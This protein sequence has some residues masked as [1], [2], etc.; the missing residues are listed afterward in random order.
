MHVRVRFRARMKVLTFCQQQNYISPYVCRCSQT[1]GRN[2]CSIVSGDV[3]LFV[4]TVSTSCREFTSQFGL[5]FFYTPKTSK[6]SGKPGCQ[7]QCLFQWPVT[8]IVASGSGRHGWAPTSSINLYDGGVCV[9]V[10][11]CMRACMR[12]V[13]AIYDNNI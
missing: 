2:S 6:T 1:A 10:R 7:R 13:F 12:D 11:L 9:C 3:S 4:S 8:G 5:E